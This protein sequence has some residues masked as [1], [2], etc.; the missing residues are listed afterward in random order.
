MK[1]TKITFLIAVTISIIALFSGCNKHNKSEFIDNTTG[2]QQEIRIIR[3]DKELFQ[4]PDPDTETFLKNLQTKY[5][6]MFA[7]SLDDKEYLGMIEKFISDNYL[8]DAQNTVQR[9][10]PDLKFLEKDLT[11]AFANLQKQH[12][13][14]QLPR[15]LFSMIFGPAE[16]SYVFDN[17]CY[18][19]GDYATIA[20]DAYSYPQIEKNP[21]Y[22]QMPQYMQQTL[23]KNYIAPDFMR[24]YLK[25]AT[26]KNTPSSQMNPDCTLLDYI[27]EE[28]KYSYIVSRILPKH[29]ESEILRYTDEQ[30]KGCNENE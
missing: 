30:L 12:K 14:T 22:T 10:Y 2:E 7:A 5:P 9:N 17:R 19:N 3:F 29:T 23:N 11:S 18:T 13:D 15:R 8:L 28:G 26:Y 24:M 27:V 20:L 4:K 25:N 16:F 21:Y 6:E 1:I